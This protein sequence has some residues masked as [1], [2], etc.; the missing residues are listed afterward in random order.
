MT[1]GHT[2]FFSEEILNGL[3][4]S[5]GQFLENNGLDWSDCCIVGSVCISVRGLRE[6]GDID[7]CVAPSH[8]ESIDAVDPPIELATNKYEHIGISDDS[9]VH[10]DRYH[11]VVEGLKII[12]PEI[13]YSHKQYRQWEKDIRD[14]E[15]LNQYRIQTGDWNDDIVIEDYTPSIHHLIRR[16]IVS[17]RRDGIRTTIGHGIELFRR[18]GPYSRRET[19]EYATK[20]IS[21]PARAIQ[22][23]REAG[24]KKT[25]QRGI[26]LVQIADPTG[27]L[28]RYS[29]PRHKIKVGTLVENSLEL[30][31]P[32]PELL[33]AQYEDGKFARLDLVVNLACIKKYRETGEEDIDL[34]QTYASVSDFPSIERFIETV[35]EYLDHQQSPPV[36]IGYSSELLDVQ[37]AA[38]ALYKNPVSIPVT[39]V[40]GTPIHEGYTDEW[41][42]EHNFADADVALIRSEFSTLLAQSGSLFEVILWPPVSE[43]FEE[44]LRSMQEEYPVHSCTR[45][46]FDQE[47]FGEFVRDIYATQDDV[48][49]GYIEEKI[50][51]IVRNPSE[52]LVLQL[53]V[54]RPRIRER[55]SHEMKELKERYRARYNPLIAPDD[56]NTRRVI[57]ATDDYSH[58]LATRAVIEAYADSAI[59]MK[60]ILAID[61]PIGDNSK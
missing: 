41:F 15:L 46:T 21:L 19:N 16:G 9:V 29:N 22:S 55:N 42:R 14:I 26:R 12:R 13:E 7:V 35:D 5:M 54:P 43:Y 56:P 58:N 60:Q 2:G 24:V 52:I 47:A 18:H 53:E 51:E 23:Y 59:D 4:E 25:L 28:Q 11:E 33:A 44:I 36:P 34:Y 10:D 49:W 57:H 20:P 6:H 40:N 32:A 27:L 8:R 61:D 38:C 31:Y 39:V 45:Y 50:E 1:D 37:Q 3:K 30:Q 48:R 17:F